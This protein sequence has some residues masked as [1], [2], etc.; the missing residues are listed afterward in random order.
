MEKM[1]WKATQFTGRRWPC[2]VWRAGARGSQEVG[3]W[4][5]RDREVGVAES[6]SDCRLALRVSSSIILVRACV[7]LSIPLLMM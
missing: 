3:S 4:F 6:S 5:R 7:S 2:K 1:G